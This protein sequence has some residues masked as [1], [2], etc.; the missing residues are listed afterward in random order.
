[1]HWGHPSRDKVTL[2]LGDAALIT[3][4]AVGGWYLPAGMLSGGHKALSLLVLVPAFLAAMYVCNLY[5]LAGINGLGTFVKVIV[6]VGLASAFC[7]GFFRVFQWKNAT[8]Y[9]SL[10]VCTVVVPM[11]TYAWRRVYFH[12]ARRLRTP[13]RLVV[14]GSARDGEILNAAI[15][16]VHP[17]YS[18]LGILGVET[19]RPEAQRVSA[20]LPQMTP[21]G[22]GVAASA[23]YAAGTAV[24]MAREATTMTSV[25][26]GGDARRKGR[27]GAQRHDDAGARGSVDATAIQRDTSVLAAGLL[28]ASIG[29][30]T[31]GDS[32]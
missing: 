27:C 21:G 13:E 26:G 18:M 10:G 28:H 8:Y 12:S 31:A 30:N 29:G 1:M 6:A 5:N 15:D 17:R 24:A 3:L 23:S 22:V 7:E 32:E 14:V 9:W 16:Q 19:G 25:M 20:P 2:F 11:A 4:A